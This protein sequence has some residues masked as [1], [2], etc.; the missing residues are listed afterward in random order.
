MQIYVFRNGERTGPYSVEQLALSDITPDTLV[1][2][3]GLSQ[4]VAAGSVDAL[5]HIFRNSQT[6]PPPPGFSNEQYPPTPNRNKF[7]PP[8]PSTFMSLAVVSV[9]LSCL[10]LSTGFGVISM[11]FAIVAI[12]KAKE[13]VR[14]YHEGDYVAAEKSSRA[15]CIWGIVSVVTTVAL[16]LLRVMLFV[17]GYK[18]LNLL[19]MM[20]I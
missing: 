17:S 16:I 4:W 20:S 18:I 10:S 6:P 9:V 14:R 7:V 1:W 8:C 13:V 11:A 5:S 15:A 3:Q 19:L 12:V 2:Y